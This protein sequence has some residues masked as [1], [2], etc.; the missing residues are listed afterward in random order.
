M[1]NS[2]TW[3]GQ[4]L[5]NRYRIDELL[6]HGGMSSVYKAMDL[7]LK[8]VV[9]VKIIHPHLAGEAEFVSRFEHEAAA[10]ARLNHPNIIQVFDFDHDQDIYYIVFEYIPGET[11][12]ERLQRWQENGM[13]VSENEILSI[14]LDLAAALSYAHGQDM[15]HRDIKPANIMLDVQ[16]RAVLMDFGIVKMTGG[17][18]H[19][20]SGALIG[21]ARYMSPEQVQG[22]PIDGRSDI[23]SLGVTLFE[24]VSGRP[25]FNADSAMSLMMMHVTDPVPDLNVLVPGVSLGLVQLISACMSKNP[26]SRIASAA[27]LTA[28]IQRLQSPG[29]QTFVEP[30]AKSD[31]GET[32][33]EAPLFDTDAQRSVKN[34][35]RHQKSAARPME[36]RPVAAH[37]PTQNTRRTSWLLGS[38]LA[39]VVVL[40]CLLASALALTPRM[41]EWVSTA[42][43]AAQEPTVVSVEPTLVN[44]PIGA[45]N[46][47]AASPVT[48]VVQEASPTSMPEQVEPTATDV[49]ATAVPATQEPTATNVPPTTVPPTNTPTQVPPTN[50]PT[51]TAVPP[52]AMPGPDTLN[53]GTKT[54]LPSQSLDLDY[55]G[56]D[57]FDVSY[58]ID[59]GGN[60][61]L[62]PINGAGLSVF[63]SNAPSYDSCSG[64]NMGTS[65]LELENTPIGTY[66]CYLTDNGH[67][68]RARIASFD[69]GSGELKIEIV[70]WTEF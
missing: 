39:G 22:R 66:V 68:G 37:R 64:M 4:L 67:Y 1:M 31:R 56:S 30:A 70:T 23:Y 20:A 46:T 6:G 16:G 13:R 24:A 50:T 60:H 26:A 3:I 41:S 54:L 40:G 28:R 9:A 25:P 58:F 7:N 45:E 48:E 27:A 18:S 32:F 2:P 14:T 35:V 65:G 8:R 59:G 17:T 21:T 11:L 19:T 10:V 62:A 51:A 33:I 43:A 12:Q 69:A 63:G 42:R 57:G 49:P 53:S 61:V 44:Q 38:G 52:T 47:E 5:S 36:K 34:I 15:V 29:S 55:N